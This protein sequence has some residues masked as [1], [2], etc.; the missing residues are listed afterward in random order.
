MGI[1]EI[2]G[3]CLAYNLIR[4]LM[5]QSALLSNLLPRQISFKHS[6]QLSLALADQVQQISDQ[7]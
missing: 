6:L 5:L 4:W 2:W 3:Y 1:K 7:Y